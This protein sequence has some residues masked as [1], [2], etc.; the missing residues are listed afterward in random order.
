[1]I[2]LFIY[3]HELINDLTHEIDIFF[4]YLGAMFFHTYN[5]LILTLI[6]LATTFEIKTPLNFTWKWL[7]NKAVLICQNLFI[8]GRL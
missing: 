1:M 3:V 5:I 7:K 6:I 8:L 2:W 4:N